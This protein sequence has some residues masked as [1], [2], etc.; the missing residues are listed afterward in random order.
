MIIW[1]D[2]SEIVD[3][4]SCSN[5]DY[6]NSPTSVYPTTWNIAQYLYIMWAMWYAPA[7]F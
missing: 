3:D 5:L 1:H 4:I 6:E 2:N 7:K